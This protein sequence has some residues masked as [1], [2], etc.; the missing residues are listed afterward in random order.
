MAKND[1]V[2]GLAI[3][4]DTSSLKAGLQ[5]AGRRI[6]EAG[7]EFK[8]TTAGMDDWRKSSEGLNAK[9]KQLNSNLAVQNAA[10]DLMQKEYEEAGYSQD[11]MSKAAINLRTDI[12]K[13]KATIAATEKDI[14]KYSTSLDEVIKSESNTEKS[15]EDTNKAL[16]EQEQ[17][18]KEVNEGFTVMK[19]TLAGLI[20]SGISKLFS[21]MVDGAKT[22]INLSNDTREYREDLGKLETAFEAAGK[23]TEVAKD[24]YEK[25]YSVLGEEDRSVEAVNHLAQFV[26]T[27]EDMIKWTNI[28]AGVWG[29]FGDSLPIEGLTEAANETSKT[30]KVTGVLADALNWAGI[31][32]DEFNEKLATL[33]S[34]EER[35]ALITDTLNG[36]YEEAGEKYRENNAEVI[37]AREEQSKYN[38]VMAQ[39]GEKMEPVNTAITNFKTELALALMEEVD[40]EAATES[41]KDILTYVKDN[42]IPALIDGL[43]WVKDHLPEITS[44]VIAL[45]AGFTALKVANIINGIVKAVKAWTVATKGMTVAQKALNLATKANVIGLIVTAIVGLVMWIKHLWDTNEEFREAVIKIWEGIKNTFNTVVTAIGNFFK[46]MVDG[47][48]LKWSQFTTWLLTTI[49]S[50]GQWFSNLWTGIKNTFA[51]IGSWFTTKFTEAWTGIKNAFSNVGSF[52]SGI[53]ETIKSKFTDIGTKVGDT[54]SKSF[55]KAVNSLLSTAETVLNKPVKAINAVRKIINKIPGVNISKLDEFKLPRMAMGGIVDK[56]TLGIV[57]EDGKE[58]VIPLERNLGW[59]KKLSASIVKELDLQHINSGLVNNTSNQTT[60]F[61]QIINAPKQPPLDDMYRTTKN[62]LALKAVSN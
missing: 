7:A 28:A 10:L 19:G 52:F 17:A 45:G 5:D 55:K 31:S 36:K 32:E 22:L 33:N 39:L 25:F 12:A 4:L 30:G 40:F 16:K 46:T 44:A 51:N 29:T 43:K 61:T 50:V 18:T 9:L 38:D 59:M 62:L 41:L 53:W 11:D 27:E 2:I 60:N 20:S 35:A 34:E 24:T 6:K 14:R 21:S 56:A 15:V 26:D 42:V 57:G 58:A 13:Q 8:A 1:N 23:S 3:G 37:K 47:I 49:S 48:R 54:I